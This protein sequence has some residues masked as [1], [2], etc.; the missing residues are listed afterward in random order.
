MNNSEAV[1]DYSQMTQINKLLSNANY[2]LKMH[3]SESNL[4]LTVF[5][6]VK[7]Y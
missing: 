6:W 7:S 5:H 4:Y 2:L 3:G 1:N